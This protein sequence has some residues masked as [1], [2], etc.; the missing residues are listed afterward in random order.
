MHCLLGL[1]DPAGS[2]ASDN[3]DMADLD[4]NTSRSRALLDQSDHLG[5]SDG[6]LL[7][8]IAAQ[9]SRVKEAAFIMTH[10]DEL[11]GPQ[12]VRTNAINQ[13]FPIVVKKGHPWG[14]QNQIL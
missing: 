3:I 13:G 9:T 5:I 7:I 14:F 6:A 10:K 1:A 4:V 11:R 8:C 2:D 12:S